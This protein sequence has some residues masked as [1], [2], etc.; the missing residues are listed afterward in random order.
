MGLS[1]SAIAMPYLSLLATSET[2]ASA[3][4]SNVGSSASGTGRHFNTAITY[5]TSTIRCGKE[6]WFINI[7]QH[8][9]RLGMRCLDVIQA[10]GIQPMFSFHFF[11][12]HVQMSLTQYLQ[13]AFFTADGPRAPGGA[14]L[15]QRTAEVLS[16]IPVP[17]EQ[18]PDGSYRSLDTFCRAVSFLNVSHIFEFT[19]AALLHED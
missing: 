4:N 12:Q 2:T 18:G 19:E 1:I 15:R 5:M 6:K 9:R 13:S 8:H 16:L 10:K 17:I 7:D 3:P 11:S 14:A